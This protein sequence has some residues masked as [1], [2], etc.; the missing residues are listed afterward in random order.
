VFCGFA[1]WKA[2]LLGNN[3]SGKSL[4]IKKNETLAVTASLLGLIDGLDR[5]A[6]FAI[7][8]V[9]DVRI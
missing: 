5:R 7:N 6:G 4:L 2:Q 8:I 3:M 9:G 1:S